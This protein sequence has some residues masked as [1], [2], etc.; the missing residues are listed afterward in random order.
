[1][2][3][4]IVIISA[5]VLVAGS[6]WTYSAFGEAVNISYDFENGSYSGWEALY[7]NANKSIETETDGNKFLRLSYNG[8]A[9]R[10]R[11]YY[12]V[13][14]QDMYDPNGMLQIDYDVMYPENET[15]KNGEMQV[16]YRTGPGS[17]ESTF[18][19]RVGKNMKYFRLNNSDG[20]YDAV[21]NIEGETLEIEPGNWYSVRFILDLDNN[22]QILYILDRDKHE[23]LSYGTWSNTITAD[24]TPN[25]VTFS[26]GTDMCLDNVKIYNT[27]SD[28]G[29]IFGE[30]YLSSSSE[31][32][33]FM[34]GL[35]EYGNETVL[36]NFPVVWSLDTQLNG[37]SID[38]STGK[39]TVGDNPEPG[40]IIIKAE[41]ITDEKTI[42][43]KQI[44][45]VAK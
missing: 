4:L 14:V 18:V 5:A 42:S 31:K 39:V 11:E 25:M 22:K 20:G 12:D 26:S 10:G 30:P 16:K 8:K 17:S 7:G 35:T 21:K 45:Y 41:Q 33:Y 6:I 23:L 9:N 43:T 37:V 40:P 27:S 2:K 34:L 3:K 19:A 44:V 29:C 36:M 28:G 1:M 32:Q 38:S 24:T 13:K 15:G